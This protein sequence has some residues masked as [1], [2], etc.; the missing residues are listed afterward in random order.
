MFIFELY[1][2]FHVSAVIFLGTV[3]LPQYSGSHFPDILTFLLKT[4]DQRAFSSKHYIYL[5]QEQ[6]KEFTFLYSRM[7]TIPLHFWKKSILRA[8]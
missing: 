5:K 3:T 8:K 7:K 2:V 6:Q 1:N 4:I